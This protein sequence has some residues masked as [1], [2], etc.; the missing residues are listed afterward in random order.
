MP[1]RRV[2]WHAASLRGVV[3]TLNGRRGQRDERGDYAI[4]IAVIASALLLFGGIAYDAPRLIT[5]RQHAVHNANEAAR[6]AAATMA[7]G[8]TLEQARAAADDRMAAAGPLY[9]SFTEVAALQCVGSLM[10]VTVL[11]SYV[12]RSALAVFRQEQQIAATGAAVAQLVG[13]HGQPSQLG[14]LPECPLRA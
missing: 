4:F 1:T 12:N 10:E 11:T 8:G 14:Y 3:T 7:A 9:G 13:P 5:A 6:V 2:P